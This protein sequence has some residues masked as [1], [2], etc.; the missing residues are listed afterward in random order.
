MGASHLSTDKEQATINLTS[1]AYSKLVNT[2]S[3]IPS[4]SINAQS[5]PLFLLENIT[6]WREKTF[7]V[8]S[9]TTLL[10]GCLLIIFET[11]RF[12]TDRDLNLSIRHNRHGWSGCMI[13]RR[14][15]FRCLARWRSIVH[16][17]GH[18]L[19]V[20]TGDQRCKCLFDVRGIQSR[21]FQIGY[22]E[23]LS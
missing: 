13:D 9:T 1:C 12:R 3:T 16:G 21:G 5:Y 4:S 7:S 20:D 14:W 23:F 8:V 17:F 11:E 22:V 2:R 6:E 15:C 10:F 18:F 19:M